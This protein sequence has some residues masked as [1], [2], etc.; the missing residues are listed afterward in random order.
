ML[1][2]ATYSSSYHIFYNNDLLKGIVHVIPVV[3]L[4]N[5]KVIHYSRSIVSQSLLQYSRLLLITN[6]LLGKMQDFHFSLYVR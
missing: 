3:S 1:L 4:K 6:F 2:V 5:V